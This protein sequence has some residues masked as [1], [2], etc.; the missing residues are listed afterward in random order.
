MAFM[1]IAVCFHP[2]DSFFCLLVKPNFVLYEEMRFELKILDYVLT[3][4]C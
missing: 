3:S 2:I 4:K 1:A